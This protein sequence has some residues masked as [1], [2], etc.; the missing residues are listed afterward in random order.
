M[1]KERQVVEEVIDG[2]VDRV[3]I[4]MDDA[5]KI[6]ETNGEGLILNLEDKPEY[7]DY[8]ADHRDG[9]ERFASFLGQSTTDQEKLEREWAAVYDAASDRGKVVLRT[10]YEEGEDTDEGLLVRYSEIKEA[11][12]DAGNTLKGKTMPGIIRGLNAK[13]RDKVS[14]IDDRDDAKDI[15][16]RTWDDDDN[17]SRL[18]K[19][20]AD[21][22]QHSEA[23]KAAME[24]KLS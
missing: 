2:R 3:N 14:G 11:L 17:K 16:P 21:G 6:V 20:V 22:P 10:L 23:F 7:G 15:F 13:I 12:E 9:V 24:Q 18:L 8:V 5:D 1:T 4:K 19:N